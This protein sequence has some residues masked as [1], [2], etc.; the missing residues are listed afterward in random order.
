[1]VQKEYPTIEYR[2]LTRSVAVPSREQP[3]ELTDLGQLTQVTRFIDEFVETFS[4]LT[5]KRFMVFFSLDIHP[6]PNP[7]MSRSCL[8]SIL[9]RREL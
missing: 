4:R 3:I 9:H 8:V 7:N 2:W 5:M 6:N 1:M